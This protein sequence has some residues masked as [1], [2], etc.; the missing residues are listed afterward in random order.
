MNFKLTGLVAATHTPFAAD[1]RLNLNAVERQAEHLLAS[2][3][4]TVFVGGTT[5][6][7]SSL[8]VVER[9]QLVE[10]WSEV[11]RGTPMQFVV[12]VGSNCLADA[13]SL[14][15]QAQ[16]VGAAAISALAPSYFKPRSIDALIACCADIASAAPATPFYYYDI[17]SMTGVSLPVAD[18]LERA[19]SH[20]PSLVGVKFT[21]PDLMAYQKCM[22]IAEGRF[23]VLWGVDEYLIAALACGAS[24]AVGSSYNFA[25]PIYNRIFSAFQQGDLVTARLEQYR[26]VQLIESLATL[27]YM[28]AAKAVMEMLGVPVGPPRLPNLNLTEEQIARLRFRL[29][30]LGFFDWVR[31]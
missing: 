2:G 11:I 7:C 24:G 4:N 29:D 22:N 27:G 19:L 30:D 14:A 1:G 31:L 25:A 13:R 26:S 15:E 8:T 5:G 21:N 23:D 3:V 10:R 17:P 20:V 18:F 12:H 16:N 6:E 28:G 9:L